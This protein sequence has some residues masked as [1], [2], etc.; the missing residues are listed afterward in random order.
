LVLTT[1]PVAPRLEATLARLLDAQL[2]DGNWPSSEGHPGRHLVQFCHGAPGFVLSLLSLRPYFP[3]LQD[4]VDAAIKKAREC[5]WEQGLLRKEPSLCHG[6]LGN[7]LTFPPGPQRDHFLAL[8]V[9]EKMAELKQ[10]DPTLFQKA[11][12]GREYATLA[13]YVPSAAWTWMVCGK[14]NPRVIAYNDI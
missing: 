2:G 4:R 1:P 12:Y 9:P 6:I 14:Q 5:I 8:A 10:A 3:A 13:G 7:A 11:N